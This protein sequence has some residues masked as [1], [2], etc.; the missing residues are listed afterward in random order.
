MTVKLP[1]GGAHTMRELSSSNRDRVFIIVSHGRVN[2]NTA[3]VHSW[4][5]CLYK[6]MSRLVRI[7]KCESKRKKNKIAMISRR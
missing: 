3:T 6:N 5:Y 7:R 4:C 2:S 1:E